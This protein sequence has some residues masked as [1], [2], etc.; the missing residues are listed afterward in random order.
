MDLNLTRTEETVTADRRWLAT[1]HGLDVP[2][3]ITLDLTLF[4]RD[5]YRRPGH[6]RSVLLSGV[7]LGRVSETA[8]FGPWDPE[9][10]DGR[11]RFTGMLLADVAFSPGAARAGAAL[12][13]HGMVAAAH[14]PG[15]LDP[16]AIA[17]ASAQ[18]TFI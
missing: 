11:S 18:I 1:R 13:W 8:L 3:S 4:T 9:A 2:V 17:D 6:P 16:S 5:D 14:V 15:G 7:P 12:L 10:E